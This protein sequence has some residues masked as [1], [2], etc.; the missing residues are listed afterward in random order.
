MKKK[1]LLRPF[2]LHEGI[3]TLI[4]TIAII[5]MTITSLSTQVLPEPKAPLLEHAIHAVVD[6]DAVTGMYSLKTATPYSLS[7]LPAER[8]AFTGS[9]LCGDGELITRIEGITNQGYAGIGFRENL[10]PGS[11]QF[12][13][14]SDLSNY[15]R[16]EYRQ[17]TGGPRITQAIHR[18]DVQ[19]LKIVR[20]G[21]TLRAY[22]SAEGNLWTLAV[23]RAMPMPTCLYAGLI[24]YS[25][26]A[27]T[28]S[29]ASFTDA[30]ISDRF[31]GFAPD[32]TQTHRE[33]PEPAMEVFPNPS[34]GSYLQ[35]IIYSPKEENTWLQLFDTSGRKLWQRNISLIAGYNQELVRP[36]DLATGVYLISVVL[37]DETIT[38]KIVVGQKM[39]F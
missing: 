14:L 38:R 16:T 22:T 17:A 37:D 36:G 33:T 1:K 19:W 32:G 39:I 23:E 35:V 6:Y 26:D 29:L 20:E 8:P 7:G 13:L 31:D 28:P 4:L 25:A 30:Q 27:Y 34:E 3:S 18:S 15:I 10:E 12:T 5:T 21:I 11:P 9:F 24:A 2:Y